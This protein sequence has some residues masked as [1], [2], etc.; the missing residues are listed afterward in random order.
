MKKMS[1]LLI[2]AAAAMLILAGCD[3]RSE[4]KTPEPAATAGQKPAGVPSATY[5]TVKTLESQHNDQVEK[6][7]E[8]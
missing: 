8:P 6:A 1:L 7:L 4:K 5:N 3:S 2:L